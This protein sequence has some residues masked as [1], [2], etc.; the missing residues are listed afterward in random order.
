MSEPQIHP[1]PV[2]HCFTLVTT[3]GDLRKLAEIAGER[4]EENRRDVWLWS[5][6]GIRVVLELDMDRTREETAAARE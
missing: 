4:F 3:P 6:A 5:H 1:R 2:E